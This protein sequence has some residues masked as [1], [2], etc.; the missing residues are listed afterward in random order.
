MRPNEDLNETCERINLCIHRLKEHNLTRKVNWIFSKEASGDG[1]R[2]QA[3][4][5]QSTPMYHVMLIYTLLVAMVAVAV[6]DASPAPPGFS[7]YTK[8]LTCIRLKVV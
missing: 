3:K 2:E 7:E 1:T 4:K 6:C 5:L 8:I